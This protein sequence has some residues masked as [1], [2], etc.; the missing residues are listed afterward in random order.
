ML[1]NAIRSARAQ[2]TVSTPMQDCSHSA[3]GT[4][5]TSSPSAP[6]GPSI[7]DGTSALEQDSSSRLNGAQARSASAAQEPMP[8]VSDPSSD[9]VAVNQQ[10]ATPADLRWKDFE[11]LVDQACALCDG[12]RETPATSSAASQYTHQAERAAPPAL[13]SLDPS[14]VNRFQAMHALDV[15]AGWPVSVELLQK[16]QAGRRIR[17]LKKRSVEE[18]SRAADNVISTWKRCLA[19]PS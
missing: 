3:G 5:S 16:S 10:K 4:P 12:C 19:V 11:D 2:A 8:A 14:G 15:L 13:G 18:M 17:Q 7:P 1:A 9:A 6:A